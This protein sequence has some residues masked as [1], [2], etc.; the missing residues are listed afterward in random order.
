MFRRNM[1]AV[2]AAAAIAWTAAAPLYAQVQA[3]GP[4]SSTT[5]LSSALPLKK[6]EPSDTP[7]RAMLVWTVVLLIAAGAAGYLAL[8]RS[9]RLRKGAIAW[10]GGP[11]DLLRR[12]ASLLLSQNASVHVVQWADQEYLLG[13]TPQ[14]VSLLDKRPL[15]RPAEVP[16]EGGLK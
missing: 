13:S 7:V 11:N 9:G 8:L 10:R 3:A 15:P 14:Q 16:H 2:I 1:A 12:N 4:S 5:S 6:D